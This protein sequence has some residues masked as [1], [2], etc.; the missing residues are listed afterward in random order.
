MLEAQFS[1]KEISDLGRVLHLIIPA[2]LISQEYQKNLKEIASQMEVSGFRKGKVPV[3][4]AEHR[5]GT[6]I[7]KESAQQL[8][9]KLYQNYLKEHHLTALG[10]LGTERIKAD[11]PGSLG[12]DITF[13]LE[14]HVS[15]EN[16][17]DIKVKRYEVNL[18]DKDIDAEIAKICERTVQWVPAAKNYKISSNERLTVE[19]L[20]GGVAAPAA[21]GEAKTP[22]NF[23]QFLFLD[24]DVDP[25][26]DE[27][28][29]LFTGAKVGD[30]VS[31]NVTVPEKY[32][33]SALAAGT[34]DVTFKIVE[35]ATSKKATASDLVQR[36]GLESEAQLR[37]SVEQRLKEYVN[38]IVEAL[39]SEEALAQI[40]AQRWEKDPDLTID[41]RLRS[42]RQNWEQ[43]LEG[44]QDTQKT[45]FPEKEIRN[46]IAEA[47]RRSIILHAFERDHTVNIT[48]EDVQEVFTEQVN[49]AAS[50]NPASMSD[51][52]EAVRHDRGYW[53]NLAKIAKNRKLIRLLAQELGIEVTPVSLDKLSDLEAARRDK[54]LKQ[55]AK[56]NDYVEW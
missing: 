4:V 53:E 13:E 47:L 20:S 39:F 56:I 37:E 28:K 36:Y 24:Q 25:L 50:T 51:F 11:E 12:F 34:H 30:E 55:V 7:K 21:E 54:A 15:L 38:S 17:K 26:K 6:D 22:A 49:Q 35:I 3:K 18:T 16:L 8:V 1:L 27:W 52:L 9:N 32:Y 29:K 46:Y 2:T 5:F 42:Q 23:P 10:W 19:V 45:D 41:Y 40:I 33:V 14:P 44:H 31:G 43:H 48:Q